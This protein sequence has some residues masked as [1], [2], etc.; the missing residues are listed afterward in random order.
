WRHVRRLID[1][2]ADNWMK[3]DHGIWEVRGG[4]Q[5]FV[6][7][8]V[9]GWVALDRAIRL[10]TKSSLPLDGAR[11][12]AERDRIYEAGMTHGWD[13]EQRTV[14]QYFGTDAFDPAHPIIPPR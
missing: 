9:Q 12:L 2:V 11:L 10:A 14:L 7:S 13:A 4:H 8:K 5:Q 3:P 1:W 6:Y